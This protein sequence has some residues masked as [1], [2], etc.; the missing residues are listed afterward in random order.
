MMN[1]DRRVA[2]ESLTM[3]KSLRLTLKNE[4]DERLRSMSAFEDPEHNE[5]VMQMIGNRLTGYSSQKAKHS[6]LKAKIS[7][8]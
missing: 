5:E 3:I 2:R 6:H 1:L 8:N 4:K 7:I